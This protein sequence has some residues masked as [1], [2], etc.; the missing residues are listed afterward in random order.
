[1]SELNNEYTAKIK[2][3]QYVTRGRG[4][5]Q[6]K[7]IETRRIRN[8]DDLSLQRLIPYPGMF[9]ETHVQSLPSSVLKH[10]R[11]L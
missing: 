9:V 2:T 1:M 10:F 4:K 11:G 8:K 7:L 6:Y 3:E 5:G